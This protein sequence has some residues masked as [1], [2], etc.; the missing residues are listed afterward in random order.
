MKRF[1]TL[2]IGLIAIVGTAGAWPD[3]VYLICQENNSWGVEAA[4]YNDA[5]KFTKTSENHFRATVPGSYITNGNWRF[6]F[7][8]KDS[9]WW[10]IGP[11]NSTD[12]DFDVTSSSYNTWQKGYDGIA[13]AFYVP[14]NTDAKYIHVYCTW[15]GS[16]QWNVSATVVTTETSYTVAFTNPSNWTA[17]NVKAYVHNDGLVLTNSWPGNT[18]TDGDSDGIYSVTVNG[19]SEVAPYVIFSN[20]GASQTSGYI[21]DN[22]AVYDGSGIVGNQ[23]VTVNRYGMATFCSQYPLDFTNVEN[24]TAYRLTY[25]GSTLQKTQV[26]KV[27]AGVGVYLE[28]ASKDGVN[29]HNFSVAPTA[30]ATSVGENLLVGT[31]SGIN[32]LNQVDGST[33]YILTTNKD[34]S[35][36]PKFY[37]VNSTSGNTLGAGKAYLE[38]PGESSARESLWFDDDETTSVESIHNSQLTIHNDAPVYNLAGQ[39][40]ANGY[41]GVVI[42][43]GKKLV[44]K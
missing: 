33:R 41:K 36:T 15:D 1:F 24:L 13:N 25:D 20:N 35:A 16:S 44:I 31:V 14:Q 27:P 38:I 43:N 17:E 21:V 6:R 12:P 37:K 34:A 9:E 4:A 39:R 29:S 32:P 28:D 22:D 30:T 19:S 10:N 5:F 42:Q 8:V 18:M 3:D 40:V 11:V 2:L 26:T 23:T 7:R